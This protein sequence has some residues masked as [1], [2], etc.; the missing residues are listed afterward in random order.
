MISLIL[1]A[2]LSQPTPKPAPQP[3]IVN[4]AA[5]EYKDSGDKTYRAESNKVV[6]KTAETIALN[7]RK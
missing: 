7:L 2:M 5:V 1:L 6:T 4:I 3:V